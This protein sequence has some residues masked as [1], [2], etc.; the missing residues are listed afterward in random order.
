MKEKYSASEVVK[1]IKPSED[2]KKGE[3]WNLVDGEGRRTGVLYERH[4]GEPIPDGLRFSVVEVWVRIGN[5]VIATR[6]HPDK[7]AG[8]CWEVTGGGVL[9]T[10]CERQAA[11]RELYEETGVLAKPDE[12]LHLGRIIKEKVMIDSYLLTLDE[13]PT[14]TLQACEVVDSAFLTREEMEALRPRL[15]KGTAERLTL[16]GD[17]VFG[18]E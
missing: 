16:Y 6:R 10:E 8:L 11:V 15:T 9:A 2:N 3:I 17:A 12:L 1:M 13:L 18:K 7:W 5:R 14:L 4:S